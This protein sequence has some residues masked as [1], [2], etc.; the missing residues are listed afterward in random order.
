[1]T[2]NPL[3]RKSLTATNRRCASLRRSFGSATDIPARPSTTTFRSDAT[4]GIR[5][6]S[7]RARRRRTQPS[8][9]A[10]FGQPRGSGGHD[11]RIFRQAGV[12]E[13]YT[14]DCDIDDVSLDRLYSLL[15]ATQS[16]VP[17]I[18]PAK[19]ELYLFLTRY[20]GL[21]IEEGFHLL[22]HLKPLNLVIDIGGNW[23]QSIGALRRTCDPKRIVSV[24]PDP[25]LSARLKSK[26]KANPQ[27]TILE[28]A[29]SDKPG[30]QPLFIPRYR[31]FTYDGLASLDAVSALER[32]DEERLAGFDRSKLSVEQYSVRMITLDSLGLDPDVVK[33]D[34]QGYE[35]QVVR[36]GSETFNRSKPITIMETPAEPVVALLAEYD[37]LPFRHHNMSLWKEI[38][39]G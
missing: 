26:Y 29:I 16:Y 2:I 19:F 37:L 30:E 36:G 9:D 32:L 18:R 31:G 11:G 15:R 35:L 21:K 33:I 17:F 6:G 3:S 8:E 39:A 5:G 20:L 14:R 27:I 7:R 13:S 38:A 23:G 34:V 24:E 12:L 10:G 1:V 25:Y 22:S 28:N 4:P